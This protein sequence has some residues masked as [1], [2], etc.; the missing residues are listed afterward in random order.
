MQDKSPVP[1]STSIVNAG[2]TITLYAQWELLNI[3]II[4]DANG[5]TGTMQQQVISANTAT[6]LYKSQFTKDGYS[7]AFWSTKAN[8][9]GTVYQ[10]EEQVSFSTANVTLYA[11]YE[12]FSYEHADEYIFDG[13]QYEDTGIYLFSA[14]NHNKDFVISFKIKS[15]TYESTKQNT[16]LSAINEVGNPYQGFVFRMHKTESKYELE[17]NSTKSLEAHKLYN[18]EDV[19]D[20]II[21]RTNNILYINIDNGGDTQIID[22]SSL[23]QTHNYP[24]TIGVGL[25]KNFN[26]WRYFKGTLSDISVVLSQ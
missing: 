14:K 17:A 22:Y 19:H 18:L 9:S 24:L 10:D 25:D 21:K 15:Y 8:G 16:I 26:K 5:G 1:L 23:K 3:T 7:F 11:I 13:T 4:F 20:V 6:N 12:K 2:E